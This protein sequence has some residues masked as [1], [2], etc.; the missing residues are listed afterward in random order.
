MA[1]VWEEAHAGFEPIKNKERSWSVSN[2]GAI[3]LSG[4]RAPRDPW[5][6][7]DPLET[8]YQTPNAIDLPPTYVGDL[9]MRS[10]A[11]KLPKK[12]LQAR[13]FVRE[14]RTGEEQQN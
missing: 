1:S 10:S 11:S 7:F 3:A 9:P 14:P 6:L 12:V 2:V 13:E 5:I 4:R 8:H